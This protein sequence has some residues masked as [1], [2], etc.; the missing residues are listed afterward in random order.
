MTEKRERLE[1]AIQGKRADRPPV[2]LWRHFPVDDQEARTLAGSIAGFQREYD[3]DFVK[4]TP[5]S[6]FCLKDWGAQDSW[7]GSAEGTREY[8]RRVVE[9]PEDW[10]RLR[11]LD[12]EKG[13]LGEQL[14]CLR[15]LKE[16]LGDN[17]PIIQTIFSPLSQAKNLAGEERMLVHLRRD[18][19]ALRA[20]LETIFESTRAFIDRARLCGVD[21]IFYAV[22]FASYRFMDRE[23]YRRVAEDQDRELLDAAGDMWLRLL[24]LHGEDLM[25]DVARS[26]PANVVNWHDRETSPGLAEGRAEIRGAV[27]G[28]VSRETLV[29]G[30]ARG[31]REEV[32][33]AFRAT[34]G[35]EG[36]VVSTGCVVPIIAP[37]GNLVALREAVE[38][39]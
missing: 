20:G 1:A 3:F 9:S 10:R 29:F 32:E 27:C 35:G 25:F 23:T 28:G 13:Y 39:A 31:V 12:P 15:H 5:A 34:G 37:R 2:A 21:G 8:T 4:A 17:V 7:R 38:C 11:V 18:P 24:H 30:D 22:Q 36:L 6:S 16:M 19:D 26:L 14:A 33:D